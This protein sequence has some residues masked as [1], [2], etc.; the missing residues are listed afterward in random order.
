M[1]VNGGGRWVL[2]TGAT[3][4]IGGAICEALAAAGFKVLAASRDG[5][6]PQGAPTDVQGFTLDLTSSVDLESTRSRVEA[7]TG[8]QLY[9][10]VGN[11]GIAIPAAFEQSQFDD[12][13]LQIQVNVIGALRV[14]HS[15]LPIVRSERGRLVAVTSV[16][17]RLP[18]PFNAVHCGTK[19]FLEGF[20]DS[21][22][23]ELAPAGVAVAIIEPGTIRT[24]MVGKF[25]AAAR[26]A[27]EETP[28]ALDDLYGRPVRALERAMLGHISTG[29][30]PEVVAQAV[31]H[32][33]TATKPKTRYPVGR[34]ARSLTILARLLPDRVKDR[35][36]R[37]LL[38][39]GA[40]R[41]A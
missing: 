33:L 11:A 39:L 1:T 4:G 40:A 2:V 10:L 20:F 5:R 38:G 23:V 31:L 7:A 3:G 15:L 41:S 35:L 18:M 19:H 8:G 28:D 30:P 29:S 9:A 36:L 21:L 6:P 25:S 26:K 24:P 14:V 13:Q 32:A 17:G 12:A 16:V 37:R 27:Q 34:K 22:R